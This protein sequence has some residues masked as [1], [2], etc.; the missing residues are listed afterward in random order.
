[1]RIL[2]LVFVIL[3]FGCDQSENTKVVVDARNKP[4]KI[5][6]GRESF[7]CFEWEHNGHKYLII[8]RANGSGITHSGECPCYRKINRGTGGDFVE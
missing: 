5:N 2:I 6:M 7:D 4:I 3:L 8:N 1:M